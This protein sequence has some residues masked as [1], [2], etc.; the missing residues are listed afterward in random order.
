MTWIE[1]QTGS[2]QRRELSAWT[3]QNNQYNTEETR[4]KTINTT[5]NKLQAFRKLLE[6]RINGSAALLG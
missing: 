6:F 3:K 1:I 5:H 4:N 2:E